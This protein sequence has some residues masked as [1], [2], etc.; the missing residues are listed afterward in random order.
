M[1]EPFLDDAGGGLRMEGVP[2][3][4][5]ADRLG[6]PFFLISESRL[7][8]NYQALARGIAAAGPGTVLR[9]CAKTNRETAVL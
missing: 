3:A 5:L 4:D 9:Y 8:S 6:T 7:R 1:G 2:L